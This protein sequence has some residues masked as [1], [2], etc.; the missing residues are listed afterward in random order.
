[1]EHGWKS[2]AVRRY[3]VLVSMIT[4]SSDVARDSTPPRAAAPAASAASDDDEWAAPPV[5]TSHLQTRADAY[6]FCA[7]LVAA[8]LERAAQ[9]CPPMNTPLP[10]DSASR[11][12]FLLLLTDDQQRALFLQTT[13]KAEAW[14][15]VRPLFGAPPFSF[16]RAEDAGL[17]RAGGF[18]RG[19]ANMAY[20]T[21]HRA[22]N[23]GQFGL[24]HFFDEDDRA[25][26]MAM[27]PAQGEGGLIV[28]EA[29]LRLSQ[30]AEVPLQVKIQRRSPKQKMALFASSDKRK[31]FFPQPGERLRLREHS[32]LLRAKGQ[33]RDRADLGVA[34]E[35]RRIA[36]RDVKAS[37]ATILVRL[38]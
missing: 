38:V 7:E 4:S 23:S 37:T 22:A 20:D 6:T 28:G 14:A 16:L 34:L 31:L 21:S 10:G 26:R 36:P 1:M 24:G 25:Y 13:R 27:A 12:A 33:K 8:Q 9:D 30:G 5:P 15:R 11:S 17:L 3:G 18:A 2:R 32:R 19:R 29:L 35:V